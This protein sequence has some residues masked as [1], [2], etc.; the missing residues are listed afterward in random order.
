[1]VLRASCALNTSASSRSMGGSTRCERGSPRRT[2]CSMRERRTAM[3]ANSAATRNALAATRARAMKRGRLLGPGSSIVCLGGEPGP[4]RHA[5]PRVREGRQPAARVRAATC[6]ASGRGALGLLARSVDDHRPAEP[7][8]DALQ[9]LQLLLLQRRIA[10]GEELHRILH[11][12][13][14]LFVGGLKHA[15]AVDVG[16]QLVARL[17]QC[18]RAA[19]L[20]VSVTVPVSAQTRLLILLKKRTLA[21]RVQ[22]L[23][24]CA[25]KSNTFAPS[26]KPLLLL[27]ALLRRGC[28]AAAGPVLSPH[29]VCPKP[30]RAPPGRPRLVGADGVPRRLV[31]AGPL[32][33]PLGRGRR[34]QGNR[35]PAARAERFG[36]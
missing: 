33:H 6:W 17:V 20:P 32:P 31:G 36:A 29:A 14:L 30:P 10:L 35:G 11:P 26:A 8:A 7:Q 9:L 24:S 27:S 23:H 21:R 12:L 13:H 19:W 25:G 3:R 2:F 18:G 34:R 15:A 1:M 16:E 22:R 28:R 5:A 4:R